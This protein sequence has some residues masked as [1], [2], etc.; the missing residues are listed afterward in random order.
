MSDRLTPG[1]DDRTQQ[2]NTY[3]NSDYHSEIFNPAL[4]TD[5]KV[6]NEDPYPWVEEGWG[7]KHHEEPQ[8]ITLV[9]QPQETNILPA[10]KI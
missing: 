8:H 10:D 1:N 9:I 6:E 7:I 4:Q 3:E 5:Q 2:E